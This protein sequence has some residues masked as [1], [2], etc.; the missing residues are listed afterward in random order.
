MDATTMEGMGVKPDE[1][2]DS[3]ADP[4]D[5]VFGALR[6][7]WHVG[8]GLVVLAGEQGARLIKTA[9]EKGRATEPSLREPVRKAGE[10]MNEAATE[11][12]ARLKDFGQSIG[13]GAGKLE[14]LVDQRISRTV[15]ELATPLQEELKSLN[16]KVEELKQKMD[17][18]RK[19]RTDPPASGA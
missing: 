6:S 19:Q 10:T 11:V 13:R 8:L 14:N 7:V 5:P 4:L 18:L 15:T 9:A 1:S 12:G 3:K 17:E 16:V 2:Q